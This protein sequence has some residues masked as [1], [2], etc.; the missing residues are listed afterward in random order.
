MPTSFGIAELVLKLSE[1]FLES[2]KRGSGKRALSEAL[3]F[4]VLHLTS[5]GALGC[6]YPD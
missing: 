6:V 3:S 5:Q 1:W 2:L 4:A